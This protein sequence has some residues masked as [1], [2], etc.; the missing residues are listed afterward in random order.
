MVEVAVV[1]IRGLQ[2]VVSKGSR[3]N[4]SIETRNNQTQ[5]IAVS[6]TYNTANYMSI[7]T[8]ETQSFEFLAARYLN[9]PTLYWKI[10]DINP[11][12]LFPDQIPQGTVI[13]IPLL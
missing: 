5:N 7:V 1:T 10:A 11:G 13:K 3:Y 8:S 9:D 2:Q 4:V 6:T 12:I